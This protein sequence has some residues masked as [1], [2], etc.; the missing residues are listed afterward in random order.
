MARLK[1]YGTD[2]KPE[3][4]D[5]IIGTDSNPLASDATKNYSIGEIA[6]LINHTNSLALADQLI[7][8]FQ[9]NLNDGRKPGTISLEEGHGVGTSFA[10]LTEIVL[11][12]Q[13]AGS[14]II[15][16]YFPLFLN[17]SIILADYKNL[18]HFGIYNI[19]SIQENPLNSLFWTVELEHLVSNGVL[20]H[21]AHYILSEFIYGAAE[22]DKHY[23]H[24]QNNAASTWNVTHDLG[25]HPAVS[26]V[27]STGQQGLADIQYI[28]ENQLT[29]TL[30]SA[31]SG[32]AYLN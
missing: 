14:K 20:A 25:K 27:L 32:K 8:L 6:E 7:F 30:L 13:A 23:V 17:K 5:K 9:N 24:N 28:N 10:S 2:A 21:Q 3:L 12:K 26:I 11:S 4:G 16:N 31:Q 29:I 18:N 19:V 22:P 15:T 1:T